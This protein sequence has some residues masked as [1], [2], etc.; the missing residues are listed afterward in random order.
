MGALLAPARAVVGAG[1]R[2]AAPATAGYDPGVGLGDIGRALVA[3]G[4]LLVVAGILLLASERLPWLRLGHLPGD[5]TVNKGS[6][7]LHFPIATSLL[8]SAALSL[9]LWLLHRR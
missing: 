3:L 8:A 5:L 2:P 7:R 9:V 6:F 1:E 4:A